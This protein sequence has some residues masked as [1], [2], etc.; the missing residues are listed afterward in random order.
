M[1]E[2]VGFSKLLDYGLYVRGIVITFYALILFRATSSRVFGNYSSFDFIISIILGAIL[3]EAI[4][5]N[6]PLLPSMVVC[7]VIV[8]IHRMLAFLSYKS[9]RVGKFIKG[10]K[11]LL[12]QNNKYNWDKLHCC[13]L[14]QNDI[15]QSLRTQYGLNDIAEVDE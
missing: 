10:D 1:D 13:R 9:R 8:I 3:G 7:A 12:V 2:L 14:T 15:L 4:V 11:M 5:N 6:I